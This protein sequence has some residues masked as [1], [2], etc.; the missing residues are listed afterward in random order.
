MSRL[1]VT[2]ERWFGTP[3]E[4]WPALYR[5]GRGAYLQA[6]LRS[7]LFQGPVLGV[8][9]HAWLRPSGT[10]LLAPSLLTWIVAATVGV[11]VLR[12]LGGLY[13]WHRLLRKYG[14]V[15]PDAELPP[16]SPV[17]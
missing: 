13:E 11:A 12:A 2:T 16:R 6:G 17:T 8:F 5:R 15:P 1:E 3:P 7:A 10:P 9:Q 14:P 4:R